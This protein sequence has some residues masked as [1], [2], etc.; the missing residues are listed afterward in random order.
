M[1][2]VVYLE[3]RCIVGPILPVVL[4]CGV[5]LPEIDPSIYQ[6]NPNVTMD[7]LD[8]ASKFTFAKYL[9]GRHWQHSIRPLEQRQIQRMRYGWFVLS[10]GSSGKRFH[11]VCELR[12]TICR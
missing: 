8:R 12:Y 7:M 3:K 1:S 11:A 10:S 2:A 9:H 6:P 4:R 5:L